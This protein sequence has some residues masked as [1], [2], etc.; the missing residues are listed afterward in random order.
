MKRGVMSWEQIWM[1]SIL[2]L[3]LTIIRNEPFLYNSQRYIRDELSFLVGAF[4]YD[5]F[6]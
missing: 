3:R 5:P 4:T 2:K 6:F 1:E